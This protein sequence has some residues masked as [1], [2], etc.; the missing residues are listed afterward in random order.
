M[1][2][3][4][5]KGQR[6]YMFQKLHQKYGDVIRIGPR[7]LSVNDPAALS[8]IYG[9]TG[10]AMKATRGPFYDFTVESTKNRARNLQ[11]TPNHV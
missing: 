2:Y 8:T 3:P 1:V 7:E 11:S 9:G 5:L 4:D 10:V 6:P